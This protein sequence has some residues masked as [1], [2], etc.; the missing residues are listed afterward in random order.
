MAKNPWKNVTRQRNM[1][2]DEIV[3]AQRGPRVVM[4]QQPRGLQKPTQQRPAPQPKQAI[5]RGRTSAQSESIPRLFEGEKAFVMAT[6]PSLNQDA[7][8]RMYSADGFRYIGISDCYRICPFLDFFY[9]CDNR[10]WGIHHDKV[11]D[12]GGSKNGYWCTET[13]T[14][15]AYPDLK[16]ITGRGGNGWSND[17]SLIHY[18]SN[19][20]YQI[21]N[22]AY[23]L[24]IKTMILVGFNM[25]VVNKLSHFFGDHPQGLS[26]NNSYHS[27]AS[28]FTKIDYKKA[29]VAVI[30]TASPT[31]LD[32]F[33]KMSLEDAIEWADENHE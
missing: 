21:T 5:H 11:M 18:G 22:I 17:Q 32:H 2:K 24:G 26:R 9:A 8:D 27:F 4:R 3:C 25:M 31:K 30:N 13:V 15:K 12:W 10:W 33:P 14:K 28:Q 7:V 29:G 20:G 23:L 6:G 1:A 16:L 19:S